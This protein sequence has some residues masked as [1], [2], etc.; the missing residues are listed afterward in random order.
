MLSQCAVDPWSAPSAPPVLG[1]G[2]RGRP[3]QRGAVATAPSLN[4]RAGLRRLVRGFS[5]QCGF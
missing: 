3:G 4:R 2:R 1:R 5:L